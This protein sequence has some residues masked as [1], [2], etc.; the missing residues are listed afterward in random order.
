MIVLVGIRERELSQ[1]FELDPTSGQFKE[2][3]HRDYE[4]AAVGA[5]G[6]ADRRVI[7]I[8][9]RKEIFTA[10]YSL[11]GA[12]HV[13]IPPQHFAWPGSYVARRRCRFG[14]FKSFSIAEGPR[15][16]LRFFYKFIDSSHEFPGPEV[17]DIFYLIAHETSSNELLRSF[18]YFW[19]AH[20]AGE[21][22]TSPEFQKRLSQASKG[23][24]SSV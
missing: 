3:V 11:D 15:E 23:T 17:V 20:A 19:E 24:S 2:T 22:V 13:S 21:D 4:E 5:R 6:F 18:I 9:R 10:V 1:R 7:G 8:R 16:Y 12:L 14:R